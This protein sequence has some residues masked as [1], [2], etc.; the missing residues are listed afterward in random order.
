M[1]DVHVK[2]SIKNGFRKHR[3]HAT[4]PPSAG[5]TYFLKPA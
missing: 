5:M 4:T 1:G 2:K 3:S